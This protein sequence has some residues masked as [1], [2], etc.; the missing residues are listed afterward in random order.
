MPK[1]KYGLACRIIDPKVE[2]TSKSPIE[3]QHWYK[4]QHPCFWVCK[5]GHP[6]LGPP[7]MLCPIDAKYYKGK[8]E[9]AAMIVPCT[10]FDPDHRRCFRHPE[11]DFVPEEVVDESPDELDLAVV[12]EATPWTPPEVGV[13]SEDAAM[14]AKGE[15]AEAA[16]NGDWAAAVAA[17]SKALAGSASALTLAKRAE[18]LLKLGYPTAAAA[19]CNKALE[20]NPDSAKA[21]KVLAKALVKAGSFTEAYKQLCVGNKIDEDPDS[22]DLQKALK[23]KCDKIKKIGEKRAKR[24]AVAFEGMGLSDAW[25][26]LELDIHNKYGEASLEALKK[27]EVAEPVALKARL[28]ELGASEEQREQLSKALAELAGPPM[29]IS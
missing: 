20:I 19:D 25:A 6:E 5:A 21:Y 14:E 3:Q 23:A 11:D 2:G 12:V 24:A 10:N 26:S 28:A 18:A 22:A 29:D 27:W 17:Y 1:C 9:L 8:P 13:V 16:S 4:F 15:A 7:G